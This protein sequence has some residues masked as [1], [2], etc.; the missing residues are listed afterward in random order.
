MSHNAENFPLPK[1]N[2]IWKR[3]GVFYVRKRVPTHLVQTLGR[4]EI[5]K[6]LK[7]SDYREAK[8]RAVS[9]LEKFELSFELAEKELA[10]GSPGKP[11]KIEELSLRDLIGM[12]DQWY[13]D[14]R[15]DLMK[16]WSF[17]APGCTEPEKV[18]ELLMER[19]ETIVLIT[20][21]LR[22]AAAN[23]GRYDPDEVTRTTDAILMDAGFP[24]EPT[25]TAPNGQPMAF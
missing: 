24:K 1:A 3:N 5:N 25:L 15:V 7:T 9:E 14:H 21:Q 23:G 16:N 19:D 13:E 11:S 17:V 18:D 4:A 2:H 12:V 10:K 22:E 6:S 8:R 20:D